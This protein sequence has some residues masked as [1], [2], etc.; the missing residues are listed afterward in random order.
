MDE[1][2]DCSP[3]DGI[4]LEVSDLRQGVTGDAGR[5][6][7]APPRFGAADAHPA[8]PP[9]RRLASVAAALTLAVAALLYG[10]HGGAFSGG[11]GAAVTP[12]T[13]TAPT[14]AGLRVPDLAGIACLR[15]AAWSPDSSLF[16]YIGST[17]PGCGFSTYV[18]NVV[19]IY[20]AADGVLL[21][22]LHADARV[23][24]ALNQPLPRS[25]TPSAP[26]SAALFYNGLLW[27]KD[28]SQLAALFYFL[29]GGDGA[30]N[31]TG[32]VLLRPDGSGGRVIVVGLTDA[33]Q[34]AAYVTWDLVAGTARPDGKALFTSSSGPPLTS[35]LGLPLN[36]PPALSYHWTA[37]GRIEPDG[38]LSAAAPPM[39][40]PTDSISSPNGMPYFD[41]WQSGQI[42]YVTTDKALPPTTIYAFSTS[43]HAWSPDG[44]Y[45]VFYLGTGGRLQPPDEPK[46]SHDALARAQLDRLPLL[47]MRD[48][49]LDV[50][51]RL[52]LTDPQLASSAPEGYAYVAWSPGGAQVALFT[53]AHGFAIFDCS[54]GQ[55]QTPLSFVE[56]RPSPTGSI[57]RLLWSPDGR[58]LLLPDGALLRA[59]AQH[60]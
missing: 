31:H 21:R 18:P 3:E 7:R 57:G 48:A 25:G 15:D 56:Q 4:E 23:F 24:A 6:K 17:D 36:L 51:L 32:V 55:A 60:V 44:R 14:T 34:R 27:S 10:I 20:R 52:G 2:P 13:R 42:G 46:P 40:W 11:D 5:I 50:A 49:G 53:Q 43:F 28:G 16:A 1:H 59:A 39:R 45:L 19:N 38:K 33:L 9:W 47:P 58:W 41:I 35:P 26:R 37:D 22:Q 12:S 54:N 30:S 8:R 29:P